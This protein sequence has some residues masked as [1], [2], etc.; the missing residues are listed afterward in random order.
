MVK[1]GLIGESKEE[2]LVRLQEMG[3]E[4]PDRI[5]NANELACGETVLF[6]V[7]GITPGTLIEGVR[8]LPG[9]A[10]IQS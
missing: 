10:M 1:T 3:I 7:Y 6:A 2:N 8:F 5:Y 4:D 9:G